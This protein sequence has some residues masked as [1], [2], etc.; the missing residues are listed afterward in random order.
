MKKK[1]HILPL[2]LFFSILPLAFFTSCDKDTNCYVDVLVV[3][4]ATRVPVSGVEVMLYQNNGSPN[5]RNYAVG[6][7]NE[8]GIFSTHF[9]APAIL[10][11]KATYAVENNG[12][13]YGTGT[14]RLVQG[15]TK[16]ATITLES[17]I[18]Y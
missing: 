4:E 16:K 18:H 5:D 7:T 6:I 1:F 13:R 9:P 15:E 12:F 3:D 8:E 11:I 17:G 14:V 10:S 2:L